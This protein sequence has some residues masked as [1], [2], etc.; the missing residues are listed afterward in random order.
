MKEISL[1]EVAMLLAAAAIAAP[2]ARWLR[3]GSVLGYLATGILLGPHGFGQA[4]SFYQTQEILHFA[5]F[6]VVLLLFIIGLELRPR[7]LWSMRRQIF[8]IG[9]LQFIITSIALGLLGL[10]VGLSLPVSLFLAFALSLSSTAFAIQILE[11][12]GELTTRHGRTA[13]SIL[14]FQDLA[15]IPLIA[16]VPVFAI[17]AAATVPAGDIWVILKAVGTILLVVVAGRFLI[18]QVLRLIARTGVHEAMTAG[19]LLTVVGAAVVMQSAGISASLG[20]FLAGAMLAD[21][22]YRHQLE[23]DLKPFEGLLLG[24]FF[25]AIGM[26]IDLELLLTKP[27]AVIGL[28]M[29]LLLIKSAVLYGLARWQGLDKGPSRRMSLSIAQGGEFAFVLLAAG[30]AATVIT[31]PFKDLMNIVVT[32]SMAATPLL[33][34]SER[35]LTSSVSD[36]GQPDEMPDREGHVIIAGF[37]RFGQIIA[38]ILR[39]KRIPF[40]AL[41]LDPQQIEL[42]QRFGSEAFFGNAARPD[43]L[44]AA[45]ADKARAFVLAVDD[46]DTSLRT[47]RVVRSRY[48]NLKI[49]AR[50]RHRNHVHQLMDLGVEVIRRE[51]FESALDLSHELLRGLGQSERDARFAIDTFREHDERRLMDDYAHYTDEEKLRELARGDAENLAKLFD[52]DAMTQAHIATAERGKGR[53]GVTHGIICI[54]HAALDRIYRIEAFPPKPTKVRALEHIESGGGMAANAASAIATLGGTAELWSRVGTDDA[55]ARIKAGLRRAGVD[56]RYVETFEEGRSSTSAIL[57]DHG[58]QRMVVGARDV[59]MPSGTSWLPL[60]RI[61]KASLVLADMRWLEAV[62]TAFGRARVVGTPTVLDADLGAR[63]TMTDILALTDYAVFSEAALEEFLPGMAHQERLD[64]V[65]LM[66]PRHAGVTLGEKG[67][68]WRDTFGGG[69]CA[70]FA[71]DVTDTTGAGDAFHGAFAHMLAEGQPIKAC[72]RFAC[73]VAAMKCTRLGSRSGLPRRADVEKFLDE[74]T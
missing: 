32:L 1:G 59:N 5:E 33:L 35:S 47:A 60:E 9:G 66:G 63:E 37:G 21:S 49:Y 11:E 36:P 56:I 67:Y 13:V 25:T 54:G 16:I 19:A 68:V 44:A 64:R 28:T 8:G 14:L 23:A 65:L 18:D 45:E 62:R 53:S 39:A 3:I 20:G 72:A 10:A 27:L 29:G 30:A 61:E 4:F 69:Q 52:E 43:I 58:G 2:L 15:A 6:G 70:G 26:S 51:T 41:D 17:S 40:T 22:S 57:V 55:G 71:V 24:L 48:P 31:H 73:A 7:R 42:V 50:A 74:R 12:N 34:L 38:R 46:V